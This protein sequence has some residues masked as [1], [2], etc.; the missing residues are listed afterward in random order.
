[1]WPQMMNHSLILPRI[2]RVTLATVYLWPSGRIALWP[3]PFPDEKGRIKPWK[4]ARRA[5][6]ISFGVATDL[7]P[8]GPRWVQI[9][10]NDAARDYDVVTAENI[11]M[12][13]IWPADLTLRNSMKLGFADKTID[14][15]DHPYVRQLRG[16]TD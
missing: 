16:L 13:P 9:C 6:E 5:F 2:R 10:W 7:D 1:V 14:N 12:Q 8:P 11:N 4:S 15:E 3:V